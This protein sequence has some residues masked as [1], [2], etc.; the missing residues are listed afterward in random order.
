MDF[1]SNADGSVL[2]LWVVKS[3]RLF[4]RWWT[5]WIW[6]DGKRDFCAI[7][8]CS[9]DAALQCTV[10]KTDEACA[11]HLHYLVHRVNIMGPVRRTSLLTVLTLLKVMTLECPSGPIYLVLFMVLWSSKSDSPS[12]LYNELGCIWGNMTFSVIHVFLRNS[13]LYCTV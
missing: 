3:F 11:S 2:G 12:Q 10:S 6:C 7:Y 5:N 13:I 1:L 8:M 4:L 9:C